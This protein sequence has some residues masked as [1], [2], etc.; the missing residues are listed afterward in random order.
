V[1]FSKLLTEI[2]VGGVLAL[3]GAIIL[4]AGVGLGIHELFPV[5]PLS[6]CLLLVGL[7]LA[8][9]GGGL[10]IY[11][12]EKTEEKVEKTLTVEHQVNQHPMVATILAVLAGVTLYRLVMG[13]GH[14]AAAAP[15][16][17]PRADVEAV[18]HEVRREKPGLWSFLGGQLGAM[19]PVAANVL[20]KSGLQAAGLPSLDELKKK[21]L[22]ALGM[23]D[24]SSPAREPGHKRRSHRPHNGDFQ[25]RT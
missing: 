1:T 6:V 20:L 25:R 10:I 17:V 7:L 24:E 18:R 22:A 12:T 14:R 15:A 2:S 3:V 16:E 9:V 23:E 4:S 8:G 11:G 19:I 13:G 5:L 21:A